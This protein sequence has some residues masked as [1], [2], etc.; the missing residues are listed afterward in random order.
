[1]Y[2]RIQR[3]CVLVFAGHDPSGG[4]GIQADIEAI[5][6]MG[7]HALPI[8][9]ALTVQDNNRVRAVYPVD[10]KVIR[11]QFDILLE[12][13][14]IAA[15][16]IGIVGSLENANLIAQ[17]VMRLK[18]RQV[19]TPVIVDP[20]LGS[21]GGD[22]LSIQDAAFAVRPVL[23]CAT[24]ITPNLPE[25]G[26]LMSG[27]ETNE[28]KAKKLALQ[29]ACDVLLKGGHGTAS[30]VTN[31]WFEWRDEFQAA[32]LAKSWNWPRISDAFHGTGCTLAAAIA[33]RVALGESV[34]TSLTVAQSYVQRCLE[35]AYMVA[36]GQLIPARYF[37]N[38]LNEEMV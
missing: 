7:A 1:M 2:E 23:R 25:L 14:P 36:P 5:S 8:V 28:D 34:G 33:A 17:C 10:V 11:E 21:G 22:A 6:A 32:S 9:T 12:Q 15:I 38:T 13:I 26:R 18:E 20:V 19:A 16:K 35:Q 29:F 3:P 31:H 4:A 24:L 27:A 37:G 30:E